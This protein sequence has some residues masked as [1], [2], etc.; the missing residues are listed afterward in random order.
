MLSAFRSTLNT[1]PVRMFFLLLVVAFAVWGVG[2]M[3]RVWFA[4]DNYAAKVAGYRIEWPQLQ[5]AYQRAMA[6]LTRSLG[7]RTEP[8]PAMRQMV[9]DQ[10]IQQLVAQ[11][12]VSAEVHRMGLQV[13]DD[14]LRQVTYAM[15]AFRGPGG[16]FD[17]NTFLGVLQR[18]GLDEARFIDMMRADLADKQLLGAVRAGAA[19]PAVLADDLFRFRDEK[20]V[21]AAVE[22]PFAAAPAPPAPTEAQLRRYW[23]NHPDAFS[24][25]EYRRIKLVILTPETLAKYMTVSDEDLRAAYDQR[26]AEFQVPEKRSLELLAAPDEAKA[27]ALAEKWQGGADWAAMEQ[28]A[29]QDGATATRFDDATEK[30]LPVPPLASAVF[31]ATPDAVSA[32]VKTDLG[33]YVVKVTKVTPPDTRSFEQVKDELRKQVAE[34]KA[35]DA[36]YDRANK[37]EDAMAGGTGLSD[38]P[39]DLGL[40]ALT[41]TLDAQGNTQEGHPAPIPGPP[42]LKA[43]VLTA[44]FHAKPGDPAHLTEVPPAANAAGAQQVSSYYALE[45]ESITPPA[46]RPLEQVKDQ[47][48]QA[49]KKDAV[50][51]EQDAAAAGI[52]A[53]VK[54]RQS[55]E[56][57]ALK[58]GVSVRKLP[59]VGRNG[60]VEGVPPQLVGPLFALK[61]GEPTMV[62]TPTGFLVAVLSEIRQPDPKA[63]PGAYDQVRNTLR[64]SIGNDLENVFVAALRARDN[65]RINRKMVDSLAQP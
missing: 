11:T 2:D 15:P 23:E 7:G 26:K 44:A 58:A 61:Q 1:W 64:Q 35:A 37:V 14:A 10:A 29:K 43:A 24:S 56:D 3:V 53:A 41:G 55:L 54:G 9:A 34:Q 13:T 25:P 31:A 16:Q 18:N 30:E 52:L 19:A 21:A 40:A 4:G 17:R 28:A 22:L 60:N 27:K 47:V 8:T 59:P 20:R 49:W 33:W 51:H 36:I 46:V 39:D 5:Q 48:E 32:P 57:A 6:Q 63:D 12:A 62:E 45:V 50:R 65:P 38:L 42:E